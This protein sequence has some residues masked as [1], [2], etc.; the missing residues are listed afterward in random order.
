M[1]HSQ[2]ALISTFERDARELVAEFPP[3]WWHPY[4]ELVASLSCPPGA[5]HGGRIR[6]TRWRAGELPDEIDC[7]PVVLAVRH[8]VFSYEPVPEGERHWHLNFADRR[9]FVAYGSGLLAQDEL[10]V[11]EHP[12]LGSVAEAMTALPN[13]MPLTAE[14]VPTP[15]L[16]AGV[17][18]RCRIDTA[19][20]VQAGRPHGLYGNRFQRAAPEVVADAVTVLEPPTI[21]NILAMEA[22]KGYRGRYTA[23]QIRFVLQTAI[24]GYAAA[25]AESD[26]EVVIHGGFWGCGAYG[27][28]RVLMAAL[29]IIAARAVGVARLE[30]HAA[31]EDGLDLYR[32]GAALA[33][34]LARPGRLDSLVQSIIDVGFEWGMS[35][36]N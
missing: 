8:D 7:A 22:P 31:N 33:N 34:R 25:V 13:Q 35:D 24:A 14:D 32:A 26:G 5:I 19:P 23:A 36:G 30:F 9:L 11:A 6:V 18:R 21:S 10:Q 17:E 3:N 29:Q 4:K 15:I 28:N 1:P 12:A 20:D 2:P 27:G 16:V